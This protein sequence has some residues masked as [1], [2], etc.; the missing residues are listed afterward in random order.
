MKSIS[1]LIALLIGLNLPPVAYSEAYLVKDINPQWSSGPWSLIEANGMLFFNADDGSGEELWKS[2]GT[3]EGTVMVKDIDPYEDSFC[4]DLAE[5][6]GTV[7]FGVN[8][9]IHGWELWK[10]DGTPAGTQLVKDIK[11]GE[12]T[13][14]PQSL[15]NVNGILLFSANGE[16]GGQE[17]WK[18]DGTAEGTVLV[19]D[20]HKKGDSGPYRITDINGTAF[21]IAT[22]GIHGWELWKSNGTEAGTVLVK[23]I[24]PTGQSHLSGLTN[25][26]GTLFFVAADGRHGKELW[27]SDGTETGTVMVKDINPTGD[28]NP[29]YLINREALLFFVA[30][31]G[32]TGT[33]LWKSDGTAMG[34]VMV[35]DINPAG[36][37]EPYYLTLV[38]DTLFFS[39]DDGIHGRE[40][41]KSDGTTAGTVLVTDINTTSTAGRNS[42]PAYL[43][44]VND[45]LFFRANDGVH[46]VELW[47]SDGTAAGTV[48][49]KDINTGTSAMG[50]SYPEHFAVVNGSLF[51]S[52][53]DDAHGRELWGVRPP[54]DFTLS[55]THLREKQAIGTFIANLSP[56]RKGYK[57]TLIAGTGDT[58]NR[59]FRIIGNTLN[60]NAVFDYKTQ[61]LYHLRIQW[62]DGNNNTFAKRFTLTVN[63]PEE[64]SPTPPVW[65]KFDLKVVRNG[66][67]DGNVSSNPT[68]ID[69]GSHCTDSF[70]S[71][72]TVTL[73]ATPA[74]G[75][76]FT[77]WRGDC[78][79]TSLNTT[80]LVNAAKTCIAQFDP[81]P[82]P[83]MTLTVTRAGPGSG[84]ITSNPVGIDC[85]N[86]KVCTH[87]FNSGTTVTL[88]AIPA[89]G[90]TFTGWS[91]N[92]NCQGT[93]INTN[94]FMNASWNCTANFELLPPSIERPI[95]SL[96][97]L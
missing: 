66:S 12:W 43:T 75:A 70:R 95:D 31:D 78:Q 94:V 3:P 96:P 73:T 35:K 51:F 32:V 13:S 41:W 61:R 90:S 45:L 48:L 7:F 60:S 36:S 6:K 26:A 58:D 57:Y 42:Y 91:G 5:V 93:A 24:N 27:Q 55:N 81:L 21:F 69:C 63:R 22:D 20:I 38:N 67:G 89:S 10:S 85:G 80:V 76:M 68:S 9:E 18:S 29:W 2:D 8:D 28:S 82:P 19:K 62:S 40:L 1:L 56:T 92:G 59:S 88:T 54:L 17:L 4:W 23:D 77:G 14:L 65:I 33:E 52:A 74:R 37:S 87:N 11:P 49:V 84:S 47:Q 15:A 64:S 83:P 16:M 97:P 50:S 53:I 25:V 30:N 39:A 34:T 72:T 46:G 44:P 71:G 79:G 86:G